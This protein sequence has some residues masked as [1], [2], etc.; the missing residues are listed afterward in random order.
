MRGWKENMKQVQ[1]QATFFFTVK[2]SLTVLSCP[3][4]NMLTLVK[5]VLDRTDVTL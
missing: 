3:L 2:A 4:Y 5:F 1:I